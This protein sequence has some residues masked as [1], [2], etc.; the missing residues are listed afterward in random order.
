MIVLITGASGSGK[1]T[2]LKAL[3]NNLPASTSVHFFDDI[4]VPSLE[5]M[6]E[7]YG[8]PQK[9]QQAATHQWIEKLIQLTDQTNILEGSFNPEYAVE[10]L[11]TK[12]DVSYL[13]MCLHADRAIREQRLI[14]DR[15]Q[16]ELVT[17]DMNNFARFLMEKTLELGGIIID[18]THKSVSEVEN[19][20]S[21]CI[22]NIL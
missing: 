15:N 4:G 8:S 9:W 14:Y 2:T 12:T 1:T 13:I 22:T 5:E 6:I 10:V 21:K 18:T 17:E 3:K 11:K 19:E 7:C 16:P 20:M